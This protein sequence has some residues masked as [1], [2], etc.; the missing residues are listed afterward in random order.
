[1]KNVWR[2]IILLGIAVL[3]SSVF[4]LNR[5]EIVEAAP[6]PITVDQP[7]TPP[8]PRPE[9]IT[10]EPS[11][12]H[13]W[14]P[15][16]WE[17]DPNKWV[18]VEG[19]WDK[20]PILPARWVTGYWKVEENR[21]HWHAGHWAIADNGVIVNKPYDQPPTPQQVAPPPPSPDQT[22]VAGRWDWNGHWVWAPGYFT[23]KPAPTATWVS[24]HWAQ[25]LLGLYRWIPA[26]WE[27]G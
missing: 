6:G 23:V 24:G 3:F 2:I 18:W 14:I 22:W 19:H 12:E 5:K 25:G 21:Y 1:M 27:N 7:L 26:H 8:P 4:V 15:G 9:I 16:Y 11:K 17:R 20:P 10:P 13:V